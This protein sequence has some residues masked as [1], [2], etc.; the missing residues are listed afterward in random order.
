MR[1][2]RISVPA[3]AFLLILGASAA[4]G[5]SP[6]ERAPQTTE[7]I[8]LRPGDVLQIN[9]WPQTDLS[10]EFIVEESGYVYLPYLQEVEAAGVSINDLRVRLREGYRGV[11]QNPVVTITP[12]FRVTIMGQ[13]QRPGI[14]QVTPSNSL[15]D[16][17]GMAGGFRNDADPERMTVV[18]PGQVIEFD[19]L[20]ALERGEDLDVI[21]LRSG[22][23]V[24]VPSRTE[25]LLTWGRFMTVMQT[26]SVI[27][28]AWSR[29]R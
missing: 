1:P 13:V 15:F 17:I 8:R 11:M 3:L 29:L 19:A 24:I 5:Q 12:L 20:R 28:L 18:R 7:D 14:Y 10:G 9:V 27:A 21:R 22:D 2:A 23:Q 6:G 25:R 16:V 26:V 4:Q